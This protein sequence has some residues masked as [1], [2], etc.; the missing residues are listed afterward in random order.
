MKIVRYF[1]VPLVVI[2]AV[3]AGIA[4]GMNLNESSASGENSIFGGY[5]TNI[6]GMET[7]EDFYN[8]IN[9]NPIDKYYEKKFESAF[10]TVDMNEVIGEWIEAYEKEI[11]HVYV[12]LNKVLD[13][14]KEDSPEAVNAQ[15]TLA[16]MKKSYEEYVSDYV[17]F[18]E[19]HRLATAGQGSGIPAYAG[20][21]KLRKDRETLYELA[22]ILEFWGEFKFQFS[23]E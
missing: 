10:T 1:V 18:S 13:D 3:F 2:I 11:D 15:K 12:S 9:N 16:K 14:Y 17:R 4:I 22:E 23:A 20:M 6:Y 19:E 8:V 21:N 5:K 7:T